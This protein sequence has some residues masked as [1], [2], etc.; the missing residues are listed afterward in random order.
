MRDYT[1]TATVTLQDFIK[2]T[3][4]RSTTSLVLSICFEILYWLLFPTLITLTLF[5]TFDQGV[6]ALLKIDYIV[7]LALVQLSGRL[8][9]RLRVNAPKEIE[10]S[11]KAPIFYLRSFY[12]E[13]IDKRLKELLEPEAT[14]YERENDDETCWYQSVKPRYAIRVLVNNSASDY[15]SSVLRAY[16]IASAG[17]R[18][19]SHG[20]GK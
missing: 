7:L 15:R 2:Y 6:R 12:Y 1:P 5:V 19:L 13:S 3:R 9:K 10:R 16:R 18:R 20:S 4:A 11:T 8:R 17:W 14:L